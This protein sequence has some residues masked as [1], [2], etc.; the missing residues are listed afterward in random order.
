MAHG[1]KKI[2]WSS[3]PETDRF[4]AES[5]ARV[6]KLAAEGRG[7]EALAESAALLGI[8][9]SKPVEF[10]LIAVG[11][12]RLDKPIKLGGT[13]PD[14]SPDSTPPSPSPPGST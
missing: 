11:C 9:L 6:A 5:R 12:V 13:A 2:H 8:D 14:A 4:H 1:K 3:D 7:R 10:R